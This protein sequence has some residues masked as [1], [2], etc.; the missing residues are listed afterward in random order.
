[1]KIDIRRGNSGGPVLDRMG[2]VVGVVVAK[3][4]TPHVFA[5]TGKV[6]RDIGVAIR[7]SLVRRFLRINSVRLVV[8]ADSTPM[9]DEDLFDR[10]HRFVGQI[11]CWR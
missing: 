3:V 1:M 9:A 11:G 7:P 5:T 4:N 6:V 2:R 10:A 8:A